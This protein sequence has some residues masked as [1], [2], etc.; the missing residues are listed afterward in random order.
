MKFF[1]TT[2]FCFMIVEV[3]ILFF[4]GIVDLV[5]KCTTCSLLVCKYCRET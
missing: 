2:L 3:C 1:P 4:L 5:I